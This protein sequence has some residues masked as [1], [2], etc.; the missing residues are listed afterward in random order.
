MNEEL[1]L[2]SSLNLTLT[3]HLCDEDQKSREVCTHL[4]IDP[5][6]AWYYYIF[7]NYPT[8]II[9]LQVNPASG[10]ELEIVCEGC[11]ETKDTFIFAWSSILDVGHYRWLRSLIC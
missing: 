10:D 9:L 2:K 6:R 5:P 11:F 7:P 3:R 4:E 8:L 1:A